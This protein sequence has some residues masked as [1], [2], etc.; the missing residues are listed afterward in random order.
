L[1]PRDRYKKIIEL[2]L[3]ALGEKP[4]VGFVYRKPG[5]IHKARWMAAAIYGIKMYLSIKSN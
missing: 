3:I 1:L 4:S 2:S 5:A